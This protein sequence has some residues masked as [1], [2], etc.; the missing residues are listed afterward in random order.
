MAS[1]VVEFSAREPQRLARWWA[2]VL[3]WNLDAES[4]TAVHPGGAGVELRFVPGAV[5]KTAKNGVHLDLRSE[6][7][8]DQTKLVERL[9]NAGARF[10]DIDQSSDVPWV[11]MA[12]VEGNELCVLEP[13]KIYERTGPI[14]AIVVDTPDPR[15]LARRWAETTGMDLATDSAEFAALH[16][17]SGEG[18]HLEF[19]AAS[20]A[21]TGMLRILPT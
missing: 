21:P 1:V 15:S 13:R 5:D 19:L 6:S 9:F 11:V 20:S 7:H 10:A 18:P 3:G 17:A 2:D 16:P 14:A 8:D 4:G 12:D